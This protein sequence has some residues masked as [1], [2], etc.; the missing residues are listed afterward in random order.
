MRPQRLLVMLLAVVTL[1]LTGGYLFVY[2]YRWEWNRAIISGIIFLAA[3]VAVIGWAL[4]NKL[5]EL[6][7][8]VD[9]ARADRIARHLDASR[10]QP[11]T[12][13]DWLSPRESR[14]SVFVPILMGAGLAISGLAWVVEWLGRNTAG[15]VSDEHLARSLSRLAP[16]PAGF[17]DDRADPLRDI[18]APAG[19]RF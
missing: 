18:R 4:N 7:R 14:T 13:F 12:A 19:G 15:R 16:P 17:L 10:N 5:N 8:S 6:G 9:R 3:E 11:S 2:L 1:A